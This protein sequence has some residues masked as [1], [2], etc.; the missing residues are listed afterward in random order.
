[1]VKNAAALCGYGSRLPKF[2]YALEPDH[3]LNI[4]QM[5]GKLKCYQNGPIKPYPGHME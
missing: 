3:F 2:G 1:M 4:E 5:K